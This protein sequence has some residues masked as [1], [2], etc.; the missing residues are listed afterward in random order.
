[1]RTMLPLLMT[2]M[3]GACGG[4]GGGSPST[5]GTS[6]GGTTPSGIPR[7]TASVMTFQVENIPSSVLSAGGNSL[8]VVN[9]VDSQSAAPITTATVSAN[10]TSLRYVDS[11]KAYRGW[12]ILSTGDSVTLSATIGQTAYR[13]AGSVPPSYPQ[14]QSPQTPT[15]D[16]FMVDF[17]KTTD[18]FVSWNGEL[19]NGN[20]HYAVAVLNEN[21]DL[22][23]PANGSLESAV[24]GKSTTIPATSILSNFP[25][26]ATG[27]AQSLTIAGAAS[28]STLTMGA[29]SGSMIYA[30][31]SEPPLTLTSLKITPSPVSMSIQKQVQL[32]V[33]GQSVDQSTRTHVQDLTN[34]VVWSSNSP[35][36]VSVNATGQLTAVSN[37]VATITAQLNGVSTTQTVTVFQPG[38]VPVAGDAY[39]YQ[40]NASHTGSTSFSGALVFPSAAAWKV[41]LP[42]SVSYPIITS[43]SVFVL[44]SQGQSA[45]NSGVSM[46][47]FDAATGSPRWGPVMLT[48]SPGANFAYDQGRLITVSR[49]CAM[50]GFDATNGNP[51]WSIN[52]SNDS[53]WDCGSVPTAY[54]GIAYVVGAGVESTVFAIDIASGKVMWATK[55]ICDGTAPAVTDDGVY[56][57]GYLQAYKLDP[58]SG[59]LIWHYVGP[60]FGGGQLAAA[61]YGNQV[62]MRGFAETP[63][64]I[65][66][67]QTSL[68]TGTFTSSAIPSFGNGAVYFLD[69]SHSLKAMSLPGQ[70]SLWAATDP[71]SIVSAPVVVNNVVITGTASGLVKAYDAS[72]G[73]PVWSVTAGAPMIAADGVG[74]MAAGH[75]LLA[76]AAS[77][78]LSVYRLTGP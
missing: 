58:Y 65:F 59:V 17:D 9:I 23:W 14:I 3:V 54:R 63:N 22:V 11:L 2:L 52:L 46:Y 50:Q 56:V 49:N 43:S 8:V 32:A 39:A 29:F 78:V 77:N 73:S 51:T 62:Y 13:A 15:I 40:M 37:G 10:G 76:V 28:G 41:Q 34:R 6:G 72:N 57:T 74:G 47:A 75:G 18:A 44:A 64:L 7:I 70:A 27:S 55:I 61:V 5:G 12:L 33:V 45:D 42:D 35:G 21:G 1:M 71:G 24:I 69:S 20:F 19:P 48:T 38:A 16:V 30:T 4:G 66:D 68:I 53:V 25:Y 60:G 31:S 67:A 36:I 26:I